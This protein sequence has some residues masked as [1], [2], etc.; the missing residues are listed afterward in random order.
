MKKKALHIILVSIGLLLLNTVASHFYSRLD[1]TADKRFTLSDTSKNL[2]DKL[3]GNTLIKVYLKGDFP[4]DFKRLQQATQQ[5]IEELKAV[6]NNIHVQFINPLGKEKKLIEKGLEPSRLTIEENGS[7]KEAVI[8]PWASISYNNKTANIPLL[9]SSQDAGSNQ[10]Q[11]SIEN[12]EYAFSKAISEI[13]QQKRKSIAVLRGNDELEDIY[14]YDFLSSLKEKHNLAQFTLK[15]SKENPQKTTADIQKYDLTIIAKPTKAFT[16]NEKLILDQ[17]IIN[18]GKTMWLLDYATAEMDSLQQTGEAY[19]IARDLELTDLLFY[20]GVRIN[21]NLVQDL[22]SSKIAI[23]TGNIGGK[24]QFQQF[25]WHYYPLVKPNGTHP[26]SK[27]LQTVNLKFPSG[28]DTLKN[29]IKK[30]VLLQSS[31]LT[32]TVGLPYLVSLSSLA[33]KPNPKD[34]KSKQ[35]ILGVL[36][37][38]EF[39]SAYQHRSKPFDTD[40]KAKSKPNKMIVISD[41]DIIA[42]QIQNGEPTQ[43]GRDK[44]TGQYFGNKDFLLNAVDYLLDDTGLLTIRGK[45]LDI[46][47]LNKEKVHSQRGFWQFVNIVIPLLF[48]GV[49]GVVYRVIRKRKYQIVNSKK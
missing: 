29:S 7:V 44:W 25:L 28:I 12:L 30:T 49:F 32:K 37:E 46:K 47:L 22:Y 13:T 38:G 36:L 34:Y 6:N 43:L 20:Y 35:E 21:H 9:L 42:N 26:I 14:L 4:L 48:L 2:L 8:F 10:L 1:L 45:S 17:Y 27:N 24:T 33:K 40:F 16:D 11:S 23:A 15:S 39:S 19:F 41:G 3:D 31:P 5:H 18:G